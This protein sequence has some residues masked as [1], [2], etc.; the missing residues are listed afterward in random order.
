[1]IVTKDLILQLYKNLYKYGQQLKY[2]DKTF[3]FK[4]IRKQFESAEIENS[5]RIQRLYKV[6]FNFFYSIDILI[7]SN[8]LKSSRKEKH[9]WTKKD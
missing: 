5:V 9:S 2:T 4:H 7:N 8:S 3:Y 6:C 1:M